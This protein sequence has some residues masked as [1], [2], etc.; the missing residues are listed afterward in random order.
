MPNKMAYNYLVA[1]ILLWGLS[2]VIEHHP[3]SAP[4]N[5]TWPAI[6]EDTCETMAYA[7]S[8]TLSQFLSFN[9]GLVY[10]LLTAQ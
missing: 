10:P 3:R 6:Q 7:W 1:G 5:L 2:R 4:C 9:P 8:I